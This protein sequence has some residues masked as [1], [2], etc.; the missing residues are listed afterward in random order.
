MIHCAGFKAVGESVQ[1]PIKYFNNNIISTISLLECMKENNVFRIIFSSSA[2]VYNDN[3][4]L[5]LTENS[6]TGDTKNPYANIKYIIERILTDLTTTDK[7][8]SVRIARYFNPISNHSSGI[9]K[10]DPKGI[11]NNLVPC[12]VKVAQRKIKLLKIFGTIITLK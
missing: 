8:W 7:R 1:K 6:K 4:S 10:E 2:T 12:I 3:Q 11:P 9:I 5:P